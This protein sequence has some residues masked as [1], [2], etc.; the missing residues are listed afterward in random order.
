MGIHT[1]QLP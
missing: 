1:W